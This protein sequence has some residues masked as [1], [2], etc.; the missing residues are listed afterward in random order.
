MVAVAERMC[1]IGPG[2]MEPSS[3]NV[4]EQSAPDVWTSDVLA[5]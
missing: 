3:F 4:A 2:Q 1:A 5:A